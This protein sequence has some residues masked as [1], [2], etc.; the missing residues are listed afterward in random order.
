MRKITVLS[1]IT[2][3]GVVQKEL[4]QTSDYQHLN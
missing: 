4:Q 3:D 1:M 2:L